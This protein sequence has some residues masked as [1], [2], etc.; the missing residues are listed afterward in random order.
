[1]KS[2]KTAFM[3]VFMYCLITSG[4]WGMLIAYT[5][6]YN[7]L[8][9]EKIEPVSL[10]VKSDNAYIKILENTYSFNIKPFNKESKLYYACYL[11]SPDEV[12]WSSVIFSLVS[13]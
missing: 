5:K 13:D 6:S 1:M 8:S 10:T 9:A 4:I 11:T 3:A 12:R 7:K 2:K